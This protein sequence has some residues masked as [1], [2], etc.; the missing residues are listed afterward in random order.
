MALAPHGVAPGGGDADPAI[1]VDAD[2]PA[3]AVDDAVVVPAEVHEAFDVGAAVVAAPPVDVM[4]VHLV[5]RSA[6]AGERTPA[7]AAVD[8]PHS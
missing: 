1:V 8:S 4:G 3:V 2:G 5:G 6:T 7:W